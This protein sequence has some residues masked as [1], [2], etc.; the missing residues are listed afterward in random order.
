MVIWEYVLEGF[1]LLLLNGSE[2][3]FAP[4][5]GPCF[6]FPWRAVSSDYT[7]VDN[8]EFAPQQVWAL[9][10]STVSSGAGLCSK[11]VAQ[12][13]C[14]KVPLVCASWAG[15]GVR[16]PEDVVKGYSGKPSPEERYSVAPG[17]WFTWFLL[18]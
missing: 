16:E 2:S 10:F 13:P 1:L 12:R 9:P 4:K 6:Q 5:I 8:V 7:S 11:N 17:S 15:L 3:Y 14:P 18:I